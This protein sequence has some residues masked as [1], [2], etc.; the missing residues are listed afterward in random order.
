ME[1][2]RMNLRPW[3]FHGIWHLLR[4]LFVGMCELSLIG[5]RGSHDILSFVCVWPR[6]SLPR[7]LRLLVTPL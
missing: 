3:R 5:A 4:G 1:T 6:Q 7:L 2:R